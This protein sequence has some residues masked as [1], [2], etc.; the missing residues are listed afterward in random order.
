MGKVAFQPEGCKLLVKVEEIK[1]KT[2]GGIYLPETAKEEEQYKTVRGK[3]MAIGPRVDVT[4]E[5]EPFSIGDIVVFARYGGNVI[6][7][8]ELDGLWR[9]LNDEDVFIRVVNE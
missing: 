2:D 9:I 8:K 3:V 1:D 5:G 6:E 7:D 4:F